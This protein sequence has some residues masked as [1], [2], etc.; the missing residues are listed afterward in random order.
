MDLSL[1]TPQYLWKKAPEEVIYKGFGPLLIVLTT[2]FMLLGEIK[3]FK[4]LKISCANN[5]LLYTALV[6]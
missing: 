2:I 3:T 1:S 6:T 5:Q 4:N